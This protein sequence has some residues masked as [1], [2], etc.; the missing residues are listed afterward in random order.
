MRD[1]R[2]RPGEKLLLAIFVRRILRQELVTLLG[3]CDRRFD[4]SERRARKFLDKTPASCL[5]VGMVTNPVV[6]PSVPLSCFSVRR[7]R[8]PLGLRGLYL[9][10][11]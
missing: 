8:L 5:I 3:R 11:F 2:K 9:D 4:Y 6:G 1:H 7:D 10:F